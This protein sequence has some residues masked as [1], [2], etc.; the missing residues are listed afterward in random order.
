MATKIKVEDELIYKVRIR[1]QMTMRRGSGKE[2]ANYDVTVNMNQQ[3]VNQNPLSVWRNTLA[4][5]ILGKQ[6]PGF[7]KVNTFEIVES[8]RS[9]GEGISNLKL[10][11]YTDMCTYVEMAKL[12]IKSHLYRDAGSLED[13][14]EMLKKNPAT[15]KK[16]EQF[17][18]RRDPGYNPEEA[19]SLNTEVV[20]HDTTSPGTVVRTKVA[21]PPEPPKVP[22]KASAKSTSTK[23]GSKAS[24]SKK[25]AAKKSDSKS[26]ATTE[27]P[28]SLSK[29]KN[30]KSAADRI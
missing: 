18:E 3:M 6:Y 13:A 19:I 25:P 29:Q 21:A 28:E 11:S 2:A 22:P 12:P 26:K 1:G 24:G 10:M 9:D 23:S 7:E 15:Y 17:L 27:T 20:V 30:S 4:P 16:F 8:S 14:I 5:E